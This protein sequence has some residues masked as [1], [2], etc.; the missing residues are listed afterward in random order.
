MWKM[1]VLDSAHRGRG[2]GTGFFIALAHY[3][4]QE[5]LDIIGSGLSVRNLASLN[6]HN[7][8]DFK[9]FSTLVTFHKWL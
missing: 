4:R 1:I 6:L 8:L 5:G 2:L 7:K 3:H 9:V